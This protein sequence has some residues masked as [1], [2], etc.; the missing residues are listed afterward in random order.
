VRYIPDWTGVRFKQDAKRFRETVELL[1]DRAYE[2][3]KANV[4]RFMKSERLEI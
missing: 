2:D 3:V 4:V 1:R